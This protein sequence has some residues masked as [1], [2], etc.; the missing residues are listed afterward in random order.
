[1]FSVQNGCYALLTL[2]P[3]LLFSFSHPIYYLRT[4]SFSFSLPTCSLDHPG[5]LSR[6][7]PLFPTT[8]CTCIHI[9]RIIE[10]LL[11]SSTRIEDRL[12]DAG[13]R[14]QQLISRISNNC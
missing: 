14:S 11:P 7:L 9:A 10:P 3:F 4:V 2:H 5:F 12:P 13:R 6:P 1:M 8:V